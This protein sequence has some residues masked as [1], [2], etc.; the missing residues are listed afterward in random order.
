MLAIDPGTSIAITGILFLYKGGILQWMTNIFC[1]SSCNSLH[2]LSNSIQ[3]L[4]LVE[5]ILRY[6]QLIWIH[7]I[8][9]FV[10]SFVGDMHGIP[11]VVVVGCL[12]V[13][14]VD[15]VKDQRVTRE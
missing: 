9:E 8:Q 6:I 14:R 10:L 2:M 4:V 1:A 11:S 7:G 5:F 12:C 3:T 15:G 13:V